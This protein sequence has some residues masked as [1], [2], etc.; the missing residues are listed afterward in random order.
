[1]A[2]LPLEFLERMCLLLGAEYEAFLRSY[3]QPSVRALRVNTLKISVE[4]FLRISPFELS[5]SGVLDE[6]F[7]LEGGAQGA[8]SHPYHLA[9]LYYMQEPSAMSVV[10]ALSITSGMKVLD[11]CAAPGGKSTAIAARLKGRGILVSNEI[12]A[13]RAK[14]LKYNLERMGAINAVVTNAHPE[15]LCSSL[16]EEFDAVLV[17]APCSGEGMFRKDEMAAAE[18]SPSHVKACAVRQRAILESAAR[19]VKKGGALVYSTCTFSWEENEG[20]IEAFL[21]EHAEF[22]LAFTKRLYP[23]K[24]RGEGHFAARLM[25]NAALEAGEEKTLPL[26]PCMD[27]AYMRFAEETFKEPPALKPYLL[28]DGRVFLLNTNL[29][30]GLQ[31][32]RM[33]TA[34][35]LAGELTKGRFEPSHALFLSCHGDVYRQSIDLSLADA[36]LNAFLSGQT[37]EAGELR[38]YCAVTVGG[39]PIGFGKAS[40][41]VLKNHFPKALRNFSNFDAIRG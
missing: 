18:W 31:N 13:S 5:P 38:G 22:D 36:R 4:E 7:I 33:L 15:T 17:D 10:S 8:G 35:V 16:P 27:K 37:I 12:E 34:G 3:E 23:H 6:G 32:C 28:P 29:P 11:L 39:Y 2:G 19:T 21:K 20:V 40:E 24:M 41:G 30:E 14:T 26:K 25:K 9:G 1:M